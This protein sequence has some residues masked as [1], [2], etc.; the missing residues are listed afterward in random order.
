[1]S[2]QEFAAVL[3]ELKKTYETEAAR[4]DRCNDKENSLR[5]G[6]VGAILGDIADR[7]AKEVQK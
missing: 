6:I 5:L 4:L 1:M 2:R 7:L 3:M